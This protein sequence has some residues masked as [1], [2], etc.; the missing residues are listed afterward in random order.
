MKLRVLLFVGI[1]AVSGIGCSDM[2]TKE[3]RVMGGAGIGAAGGALV[4]GL[5]TGRPL[6]GAAIGVAVGAASG[7]LYNRH[8][9]AKEN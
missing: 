8:E 6:E 4:G 5:A 3:K 2:S 1:F 9:T 7:W